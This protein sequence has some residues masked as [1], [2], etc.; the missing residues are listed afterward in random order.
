MIRAVYRWKVGEANRAAF[1]SAWAET[2]TAIRAETD[3]ARGSLMLESCDDPAEVLTVAHWDS[4]E[5]WKA[6]IGGAP[7]G[8]MKDMHELAEL[9][10]STP[11]RLVEDHTV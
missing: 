6:F 7:L 3:G 5:Q 2:T 11:F 1:R 8:R 4:L 10:S 9:I